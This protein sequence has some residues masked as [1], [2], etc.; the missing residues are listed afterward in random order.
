MITEPIEETLPDTSTS[1]EKG[2]VSKERSKVLKSLLKSMEEPY[3][4]VFHLR[5]FGE[6]SF[7]EIGEACDKNENWARVTYY[8]AK[9]R[10][11][12]EMEEQYGKDEL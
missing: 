7:R 6:L 10:L 11:G 1:L 12:K 8:R 5:V 3:R 9:N 4:K 2:V